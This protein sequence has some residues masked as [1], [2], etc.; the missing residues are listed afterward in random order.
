[1]EKKQPLKWLDSYTLKNEIRTFSN[2]IFKNKFNIHYRHKCK[3]RYCKTSRGKHRQVLTSAAHK[4]KLKN[5]G[6]TLF[7]INCSNNILNPSPKV[8]KIKQRNKWYL[9]K[10]KSFSTAKKVVY[11]TK[12]LLNGRKYLQII[13]LIRD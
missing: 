1:M 3:T 4:L 2:T 5:I 13:W 8:N 7:D 12:S 9:I 6:R 10:L 11:K